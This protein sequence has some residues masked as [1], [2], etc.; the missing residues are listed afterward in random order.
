[1]KKVRDT[2]LQNS[3]YIIVIINTQFIKSNSWYF[4]K[5]L[6]IKIKTCAIIKFSVVLGFHYINNKTVIIKNKSMIAIY[7]WFIISLR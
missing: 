5:Y 7:P 4:E 2:C 6:R 1:M 3:E